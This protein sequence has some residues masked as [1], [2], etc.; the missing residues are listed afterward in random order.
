MD[1]EDS[2]L[3]FE[4]EDTILSMTT[5]GESNEPPKR[6]ISSMEKPR[7]LE[8][9]SSTIRRKES[10]GVKPKENLIDKKMQEELIMRM[11]LLE[12][13]ADQGLTE[14]DLDQ[15]R[16]AF[17][18]F[19]LDGNG[20]ISPTE[21]ITALRILGGNPSDKDVELIMENFA[22]DKQNELT[23]SEFVSLMTK[24]LK[25]P[26]QEEAELLEAFKIFDK[27]GDGVVTA[28]EIKTVMHAIGQKLTL[29]EAQEMVEKGD[30]N[31]DGVLDYK[32][33]ARLMTS[34]QA[35]L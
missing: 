6:K 25:N 7:F 2:T 9:T 32:E 33:F 20:T 27:N 17:N 13:F 29:E 5:P 35:L 23:F 1:K 34:T 12:R 30:L 4:K 8:E 18:E 22:K 11:A 3:G 24:H 28:E 16:H 19:D 26:Q 21:L 10:S 14:E 15:M 31:G